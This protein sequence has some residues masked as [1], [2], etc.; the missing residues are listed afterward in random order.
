M[1]DKTIGKKYYEP[2]D[3]GYERKIIE[4]L[5]YVKKMTGQEE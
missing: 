2:T 4:Y 3:I 5:D 1:T